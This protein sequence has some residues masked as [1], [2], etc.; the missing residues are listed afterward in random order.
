VH[1]PTYPHTDQ[2]ADQHA[3]QH[4][5]ATDQH[6]DQYADAIASYTRPWGLL[7]ARADRWL[8]EGAAGVI[9]SG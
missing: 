1:C 8:G 3:D 6:A 9:A 2:H 4:P 7:V 5:G